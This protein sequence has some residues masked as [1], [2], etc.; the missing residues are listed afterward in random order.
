MNM[1][2]DESILAS[3]SEG[4][5]GPTLRL[6]SWAPSAISI[7]YF[8]GLQME[9]DM[10]ECRKMGVDVVRRITGGGAVYH[11]AIG[12]L[13]YS[14]VVRMDSGILPLDMLGSYRAVC[15]GIISGL[16][17]ITINSVTKEIVP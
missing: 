5:S 10:A 11:D 17:S 2:V 4:A 7:G 14:V 3:V 8:Q 16:G 13:T 15:N 12:E 9:V 6:Y 1:A